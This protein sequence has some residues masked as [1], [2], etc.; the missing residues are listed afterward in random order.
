MTCYT[1]LREAGVFGLQSR[2]SGCILYQRKYGRMYFVFARDTGSRDLTDFGGSPEVD[3]DYRCVDTALRELDEESYSIFSLQMV[4]LI[5]KDYPVIY[6]N[7]GFLLFVPLRG[8]FETHQKK[9]T[10]EKRR[11]HSEYGR[12]GETC[13]I[14]M[15][16]W[17][18]LKRHLQGKCYDFNLYGP[19]AE[20]LRQT[21]DDL[22][23]S[24]HSWSD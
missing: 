16:S 5:G 22:D 1:S 20:L 2:R 18:D 8:D 17:E 3:E 4:E 6:D 12:Y 9:Y 10:R 21:L 11:V 23:A 7:R 19:P 24:I 15:V 14:V 13:G